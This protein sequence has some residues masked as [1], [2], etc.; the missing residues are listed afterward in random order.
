MG[1]QDINNQCGM[2]M[3]NFRNEDQHAVIILNVVNGNE[4]TN[5]CLYKHSIASRAQNCEQLVAIGD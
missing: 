4:G 5:V 3:M 1:H 2:K